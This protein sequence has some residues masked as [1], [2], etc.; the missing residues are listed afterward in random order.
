MKKTNAHHF[1]TEDNVALELTFKKLFMK[2][3]PYLW[4]HKAKVIVSLLLVGAYVTVGRALPFLFGYAID[5]GIKEHNRHIIVTVAIAYGVLETT[6]AVL[7]FLQNRHIQQFGNQVLFEIRE[8]LMNHVQN[9]PV[10]YFEKNP[11]GRTV[12]RVTND[13]YALGE[14]FSQGFAAIFINLI[15]ML[16]I[17]VSL[18]LISPS[19]T[20][21]TLL[22]LPVLLW[23]CALLSHKI[24]L[25]FGATKRKLAMI[26]AF[27]AE[28]F[29]GIKVLQLFGRTGESRD[30]FNQLSHE[31]KTL[32]LS[33]VRLFATLWPL[34]EGFNVFT[35]AVA[36]AVGAYFHQYHGLS[37]GHLS[38][39]ILLLQSF[40]KPLKNILERYN[41]LQNSL[42]SADRVFHL[43]DE[44]EESREGR[45]FAKARLEGRIEFD[46]VSFRYAE[47]MPYVLKDIQLAIEPGM[48]VALVGRTGSGKT[49]TISLLQ[50]FYD[51]LE[52]EIRID[53]VPLSQLAPQA[54]RPR[55]GVVQQ[56]GFVFSGSLFSNI[57]LFDPK[58]SRE[59]AMWA[60][61]QA[62]CQDILRKHGGLDGKVQER[63][64]NL[65]AG[66]RQLLAFARVLAFNPDILILDEAT[67]NIDSVS[68][69]AI[70]KATEVAT[71]GRTSVIIAHRLSTILHCDLIVVLDK[72]QIVE[73]GRHAELLQQRGRYYELYTLQFWGS[74]T[75]SENAS[76]GEPP[77]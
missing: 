28:A 73:M 40:F 36:L 39:Y 57:S 72:G 65:S 51:V 55:V 38:A 66:E 14:L 49:T 48:S 46:K 76:R 74:S 19:M 13:I 47:H 58:I 60:A 26:N 69:K 23:V 62:Q 22:I 9:L 30:F 20:G 53:G 68:E 71:R 10:T 45:D 4:R 34:I 24:R 11:S 7:A 33:T 31:Y 43:L 75:E 50:K 2:L 42:A 56:D 44:E 27:S 3:W 35:L 61:E 6:R 15:E 41:Q 70:Q 59:T 18:F 67:A 1:F 77:R 17:F 25:Q 8:R 37:V 21:T 32:Q 29:S 64:S 16:S 5:D 52:G 12:T 54:L 63:G